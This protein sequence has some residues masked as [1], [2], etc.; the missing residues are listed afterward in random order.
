MQIL[1]KGFFNVIKSCLFRERGR[2]SSVDDEKSVA[3]CC[4]R[5]PSSPFPLVQPGAI[6]SLGFQSELD[7]TF[8]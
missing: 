8:R 7:D 1:T 3:L 4:S 2:Q 5:T 6:Y